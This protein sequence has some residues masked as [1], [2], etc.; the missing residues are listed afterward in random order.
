MRT[1]FPLPFSHEEVFSGEAGEKI[2]YHRMYGKQYCVPSLTVYT[3]AEL[4]ELRAAAEAVD[5]IYSKVMRFI[6]RYMPD[7]FLE[8]PLGIH[9][10]LITAA[11][12]ECV[13]GGITRQDWIIGEAGLKCIE[14][15]T[16]TPTGI[17]EAAALENI[18]I[19]LTADQTW[20]APSAHMDERIRECFRSWL[21]FYAKQGLEGPVTFTSYGEHVEDRT[22]TT[23]LMERC[24]E[25]GYEVLYAPLEEL[26]I[27]PGEGLYHQGREIRLLYRLY[28]L[29]YLIGDRD[30]ITDVDI[31]AELIEL[32]REGQLGLMNPA[33]H[34][35]MQSKGFM[36]AIW[37]LYERNEQT[38]G[39][40]G[41]TLFDEDEMQVISR[42]LLP[43][44]F[45]A[46]PF[47]QSAVPYVA[48][49]YWGREGRGT[50]LLN[51]EGIHPQSK[52]GNDM[53]TDRTAI[54]DQDD[55]DA[56]EIEAYYANQ[57]KV[58]QQ[59]VPMEQAVIQTEE[60]PYSGYLLTGVF[61]IGGRFAGMLPR[62]GEKVTGDMAYY[63]AAAVRERMNDEEEKEWRS[64]E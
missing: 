62:V 33:Q 29:E 58:Y 18:L 21:T 2:P 45:S 31:G 14:N 34:V 19:G 47:E 46:A 57:P 60:G 44:Y 17:P 28:P 38:P 30:E 55:E 8:G 51:Q 64:W 16:D 59:L 12:M 26:E 15:N 20:V 6:Q 35:L 9:P 27:V 3:T 56:E 43:T 22:N 5:A 40:C 37:S 13:T 24:R 4:N 53:P 41:F 1:V 10:G 36:A 61:V 39:Y 50:L 25:A 7:S 23:Y 42:Y 63:C 32:V 52:E 54:L 11:R 49:S 48:K